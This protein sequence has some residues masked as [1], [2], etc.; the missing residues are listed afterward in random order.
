[1]KVRSSGLTVAMAVISVAAQATPVHLRCEGLANPLGLDPAVPHFAWQ[2][3]NLE[4]NWRQSAYEILVASSAER[5]QPGRADVWDSGKQSSGDSTSIAY[6]GPPLNS[7]TRYFWTVRVWDAHGHASEFASAAWWETGL[8]SPQAW[9]AKWISWKNS[10]ARLDRKDVR[11]IWTAGQNALDVPAKAAAVFRLNFNL[12]LKPSRAA[13][14]VIARGDFTA[15]VNGHQAGAKHEWN[16]VDREDIGSE[17]LVGENTVEI[18][19]T[20]PPPSPYAPP[21]ASKGHPA[22]LAAL[23]KMTKADGSIDRIPSGDRWE[24]HQAGESDWKPAQVVAGLDD[25][26]LGDDPGPISNPAALLRREFALSQ[27]VKQARLY[28]TALG[29]YRV[30][31]DGR[32]VGE[33]VL[34]PGYTDYRKRVLYQTYDVTSL[35]RKG[36]NA[37]GAMLGDGWYASGLTWAGRRYFPLP[38]RLM[39]QLEIT[40]AD[41]SRQTVATDSTWKAAESPILRSEIYAGEVYD[42][43]LEQPKWSTAGFDDSKWAPAVVADAPDIAVT[44][45]ADVPARVA[46]TLR[47]KGVTE[48]TPGVYVFDMGQ[49]MVGWAK[50][51]VRGPTG[52]LVRL[53]F[54]EI[55]KPDGNIYRQNLRNADAE[56]IFYLHGGPTGET[57]SPHFTF[58][59][60]RYVEVTG[61]PGRPKLD[62]ITGEVVT[63]VTGEPTGRLV[64]SSRLLNE[65]WQIGIW[66]Q[67]GNFLSVPTD[68][69]Q[70][71]ERLGWMGDAGVFWRTGTYNFDID[72]FSHN[73]MQDVADA[74]TAA[75]AFTNVSPDMLSGIGSIGAPG[76]GDAGVIVP[77]TTWLQYGDTEI[78]REY[79]G[80]M[81]R[82]MGFI[83][84]QNPDFLRTK[85]LGPDFGDWLAPDQNTPKDLIATAYWSMIAGMMS[86]MAHAIGR[87]DDAKRYADL[88][89]SIRDAFQKAYIK[90]GGDVAGGTQTAYLL[91][92]YMNLAPKSLEAAILDRLVDNIAAHQWHLST[93]FLGTP[94][95]LFTLARHGRT[96]VAYRLLLNTTYPSWGY[97][98][99]KG[100]TTWW[101]RWNGDTGDPAM[102]SYNHYAFGSVV[103]WIY[104][105]VAGID[106]TPDGPGFHEIVIHPR[107]DSRLAWARGEYDSA[108]GKIVTDWRGAPSGPF[109]LKVTIPANTTAKVYLPKIAHA[110]VTEDGK[111]ISPRHGADG[112]VV[113]IGSGSYT[114][115]LK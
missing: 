32:R 3:D 15:T 77:Y 93:G 112:Y 70:R 38:T 46:M 57:H 11:W 16:E 96:D 54:A 91:T 58:H 44:G 75:G 7:R 56:D 62:D 72:A 86:Q 83:E 31:I 81:G 43:R 106:T 25:P 22:A 107:I 85:G 95:L 82:W 28:V 76:W 110:Q 78:L 13:L 92:L 55:L 19:V 66:G 100:A 73:W 4:R 33:S 52:D 101:E 24:E 21:G 105:S 48:P 12:A 45:Q 51:K 42:A 88:V 9:S 10:Q 8:R 87:E 27:G 17:L 37:I 103:A 99:S 34:T 23:L 61:Y 79:W 67:R 69:P 108:Y 68:C 53:R 89:S 65:M 14:F 114:F 94:F 20:A 71:D 5:L 98:I 90:P 6:G 30:F 74:Q 36:K 1:M 109:T 113:E 39:A 49:N 84:H 18:T 40:F 29:S 60:F 2:S 115:E 97:M 111:S 104:R 63:S 50:L 26:R 47:P 64:T 102:N 41:G 35:V 80:A 59:G